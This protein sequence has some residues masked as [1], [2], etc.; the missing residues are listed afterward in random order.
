MYNTIYKI[1]QMFVAKSAFSGTLLLPL[2][3]SQMS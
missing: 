3:T 1:F 2:E